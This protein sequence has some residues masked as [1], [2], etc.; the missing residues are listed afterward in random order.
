ML[1]EEENEKRKKEEEAPSRVRE[2]GA[3]LKIRS[4]R[5][6]HLIGERQHTDQYRKCVFCV[7]DHTRPQSLWVVGRVN[8]RLESRKKKGIKELKNRRT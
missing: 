7:G 8:H 4:A 1:E 6:E 2:T 5:V 3:P